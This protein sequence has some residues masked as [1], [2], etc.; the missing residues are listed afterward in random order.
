MKRSTLRRM[1]AVLAVALAAPAMFAG[2]AP[3]QAG[4]PSGA[5][6]KAIT[7]TAS[8]KSVEVAVTV[9]G[10]AVYQPMVLSNPSRFVVDVAPALRI[11]AKPLTEVNAF[12]LTGVRTGMFQPMIARVIF[13][14][15]GD[16]PDHDLRKTETGFIV[17]FTRPG[18]AT[19]EKPAVAAA[20][21]R[22][23]RAAAQP[24]V[25]EIPI[26]AESGA[27]GPAGFY[28]TTI[29]IFGGTYSSSSN[30]F[31]DVYGSETSLQYGLN[32]T[33]T[34]LYAGGFQVDATAELRMFSKTGQATLTGDTA[35][36]TMTPFTIGARVLYQ[37]KYVMP[38]IGFGADFYSYE[39]EST[40]ANSSGSASGSHFQ[41]GLYVI[42]PGI[43]FL[44]LKL[45]YK[46]TKVTATAPDGF[47]IALG[48]PE[49]GIG[50]S[51]GFNLAR[52][53]VLVF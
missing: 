4:N 23:A 51:F 43:D 35:K 6:V 40:L 18:Q 13:D 26:E 47:E 21:A 50:V 25:Q 28:N 45:Y 37:T 16:L 8:D 22:P 33:R 36:F 20:E 12:G 52:K 44:R 24:G 11:E 19:A 49:Y 39:E 38:F 7:F 10:E 30:D 27:A 42:P 34:L 46:F 53:A 3:A 14:F 17:K 32:L 15:S 9:T 48:G 41:A 31:K 2:T 29:G 1:I 5:V